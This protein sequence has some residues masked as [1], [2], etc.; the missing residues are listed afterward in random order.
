MKQKVSGI[1]DISRK[2]WR[3]CSS[4]KVAPA[5]DKFASAFNP[6][7]HFMVIMKGALLNPSFQKAEESRS[8]SL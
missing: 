2:E 4:R 7:R 8:E 3:Y 5:R 1:A 6:C